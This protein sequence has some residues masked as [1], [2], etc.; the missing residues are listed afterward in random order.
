MGPLAQE[1]GAIAKNGDAFAAAITGGV[2][3]AQ[4]HEWVRA[5]AQGAVALAVNPSPGSLTPVSPPAEVTAGTD[6]Q[7]SFSGLAPSEQVE[8]AFETGSVAGRSV[9]FAAVALPTTVTADRNGVA[10]VTVTIPAAVGPQTITVRGLGS[11][12]TGSLS[13]IVV[14]AA[15][16]GST[17]GAVT[18]GG[19][20]P[21]TAPGARGAADGTLPGTGSDIGLVAVVVAA[22][23]VAAGSA[24]LLRRSRA[25]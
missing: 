3:P 22:L 10:T 17:P 18:P 15:P 16:G 7:L 4:R 5:T 8:V 25:A 12:R 6:V 21:G 13:F 1:V 23:G 24:L 19:A 11:G 14:A 2:L 9:G 20:T